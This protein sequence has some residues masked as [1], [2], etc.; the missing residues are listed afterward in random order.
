MKNYVIKKQHI[1]EDEQLVSEK[2][3][4]ISVQFDFQRI[5]CFV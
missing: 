4:S 3:V 1:S 2:N 5:I